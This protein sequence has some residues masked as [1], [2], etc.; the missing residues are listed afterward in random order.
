MQGSLL[1]LNANTPVRTSNIPQ[2]THVELAKC[3]TTI[4]ELKARVGEGA[5]KLQVHPGRLRLWRNV[6]ISLRK[7][8]RLFPIWQT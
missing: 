4:A 3:V 5:V 1:S 2:R 7:G 6:P 8:R